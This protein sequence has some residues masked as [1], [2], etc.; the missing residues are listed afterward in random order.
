MTFRVAAV[1]AATLAVAGC[2]TPRIAGPA[3][4]TVE[5]EARQAAREA[6]LQT[7]RDWGFEGRIAVSTAQ[8]GGSGRIE[9]RQAGPQFDVTLSAPVTRQSWRL[10]GDAR[11]A[12]LEGLEGG[13]RTGPD[14]D[15]LLRQ[16]TGWDVPIRDLSAWLRG[17]RAAGSPAVTAFDAGGRLARL[18]QS[19]WTI[20][21]TWPSTAAGAS[22]DLP[23]RIEAI[24]GPTRVRLAIDRWTD[25]AGAP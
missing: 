13:P 11:S 24:R 4:P 10:S 15:A 9:W 20:T 22:D 25:G 3:V 16:A 21:Y 23:S 17:L 7:R 12:R 6:A 14:A 18:S 2:A 1:L 5:A 19:G 8:Q